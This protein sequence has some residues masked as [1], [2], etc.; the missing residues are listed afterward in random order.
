MRISIK[1]GANLVWL[2]LLVLVAVM[3]RVAQAQTLPRPEQDPAQRLLQ[4]QRAHEQ[5]RELEQKAPPI[6]LPEALP[7]APAAAD[8]E[9]ISD[10]EPSF[11]IERIE[12]KGEAML[13]QA[14]IDRIIA[15]FIG[16]RLGA[17]RIN[18]L[19]RRFTEAFVDAGLLT[20]RAYV[21]QQNLGSGLLSI[22]IV[23]GRIEAIRLNGKTL[24]ERDAAAGAAGDPVGGGWL[25]DAGTLLASP[26]AV[27]DV[28]R[29]ADLE[30]GVEQ[31]NR[32]RRNQ[33]EMQILPG[34]TAGAS[35]IA[36]SNTPGDRFRFNLGFDN[37]GSPSTGV[38]RTRFGIDVDNALGL[39]EGLSFSYIGSLDTNA[40]V[41]SAALPLGYHLFS[42]TAA[43]SEFQNLLGDT[44][45]MYGRTLAQTFGWNYVFSRSRHGSSALDVTLTRRKADRDI[46][47]FPLDQQR[48]TVLRA[49]IA[50]RR[51]IGSEAQAGSWLGAL[52]FSKGL[53]ALDAS[54]DAPDIH[55]DDAHSQFTK[56]DLSAAMT[57]P[58]ARAGAVAWNWRGAFSGQWTRVALF[59]SE[60]IFAGGAGSVRGFRDGVISGD[61][62]FTLRNELAAS[63][64][65]EW[66]GMRF[67]PYAFLDA[68]RTQL[69]AEGR[70]RQIAGAGFGLR[71]EARFLHQLVAGEVL[72][73]HALQQPDE[74]GPKR[75][76]LLAS[77]N[78]TY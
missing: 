26:A 29:I 14:Q 6:D 1:R 74:I 36:I 77:V 19:L 35:I 58:L 51:R 22:T 5:Q 40:L 30:Q 28:L 33:A 3:A 42:Y 49:A 63:E 18:L 45:L 25:T 20:T 68:G 61:R 72:L 27:G 76:L 67:E 65:P 12:V 62:G 69:I 54:S 2:A 66:R 17:K 39:Q 48:L 56:L 46:N 50:T 32:L 11:R 41:A 73:G 64:L 24:R 9:S 13:P 37:Y 38:S 55:D 15:P 4:E 21:Q 34:S 10:D 23:P 43:V 47:D 71:M 7:A 70:Y 52:G 44:A 53:H 78:W 57:L 59:G 16:K 75:T 60:Q 31:I 8:I